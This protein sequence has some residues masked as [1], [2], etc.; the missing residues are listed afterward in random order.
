MEKLLK[1][2]RL[3]LR[4]FKYDDWLDLYDYLS[5][6][7]VV[8]YEPYDIMSEEQCKK[9]AINRSKNNV[10][11]AVCL[12]GNNKLIGNI[13]FNQIEP[14]DFMTWELGYVFNPKYQRKGYATEACQKILDYGFKTLGVHRITAKCNPDNIPSWKLL[15]RLSMRREGHFKKCAFFKRTAKGEPIWHDAYQ[16]SILKDEWLLKVK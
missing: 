16:Y 15:E 2:E 5:Q 9:E 10:F 14:K 8:K 11:W 1:T 3:L 13:Y 12:K 4:K 7:E 6:E